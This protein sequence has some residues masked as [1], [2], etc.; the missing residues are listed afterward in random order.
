MEYNYSHFTDEKIKV[1]IKLWFKAIYL[2]SGRAR[3]S[4]IK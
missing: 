4:F 1:S 3:S 2:E